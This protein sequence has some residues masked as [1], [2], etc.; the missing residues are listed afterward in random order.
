VDVAGRM[1]RTVLG[2]S[3][4]ICDSNGGR[5]GSCTPNGYTRGT[6]ATDGLHF[7]I[8]ELKDIRVKLVCLAFG[9]H[10]CLKIVVTVM[11]EKR[12]ILFRKIRNF[13]A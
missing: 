9:R 5:N 6:V 12:C 3:T 11:I 1:R 8:F 2:D 13:D 10:E 4:F 7:V